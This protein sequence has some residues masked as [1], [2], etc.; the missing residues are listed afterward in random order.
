MS[1]LGVEAVRKVRVGEQVTLPLI[2]A[3]GTERLWYEHDRNTKAKRRLPSRLDGYRECFDF[4]IQETELVNWIAAQQT[5]SP[6][7]VALNIV[8][9]AIISCV[10]GA[11]FLSYDGR[12]DDLI[13][14]IAPYGTQFLKNLSD[15]QRVMLTLV[16]ELAR[17]IATLNPHLGSNSLRETPGVVL[18]DELDMHFHPKCNSVS[19]ATSSEPFH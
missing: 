11:N 13:V 6:E 7:P 15:G 4:G 14:E 8:K 2:C 5:V 19:S 10:E 1:A 18:I 16:G 3:Y 17:R 9:N 12:Y